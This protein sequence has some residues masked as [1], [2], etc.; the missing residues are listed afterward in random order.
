L[1]RELRDLGV[2]V[3]MLTGDALPV[4]K[5]IAED[6]GFGDKIITPEDL[7]KIIKE[8]PMEATALAEESSGFAEVYPEDKYTIVK[9]LQ[10]SKHIVGMTGDG[11][12]DAPALRQA[13]VGIAVSNATD[14]AKSAASVVLTREGLI[15]I[16]DLVK[17]GRKIYERVSAWILS[18]IIRTLQIA[19][20]VVL[21]FLLTGN[22]V[23]S[24]FAIILYFFMTD[25][26]KIAMSTDNQRW[27]K[28]PDSWNIA[29]LVRASL[30]LSFLVIAESFLLLYIGLQYFNLAIGNGTLDT[31]TFEI[32]FYSAMF[33]IFNVRE[34]EYFWNSM[35]SKTLLAAIIVSIASSFTL[36]TVGIPGLTWLPLTMTL[37][38]MLCSALFSLVINDAVKSVLVKKF[39]IRW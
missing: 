18:K 2:S 9:S 35:P 21:S 30:I 15:S 34:R 10:A 7:R 39:G 8:N 16:V 17:N 28:K 33:L 26:V 11:V 6:T 29:N 32:L 14:V 13:E 24:A 1:I 12:N 4:A 23:V 20:F 36:T 25:F 37:F 31:F 38:V 5:E 27:S 3:K 19:T 22:Y